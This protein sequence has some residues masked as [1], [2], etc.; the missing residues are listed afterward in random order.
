MKLG[1]LSGYSTDTS[2]IVCFSGNSIW[3]FYCRCTTDSYLNENLYFIVCETQSK[4][5][6][7]DIEYGVSVPF[8]TVDGPPGCFTEL[9]TLKSS[10]SR[11]LLLVVP[12]GYNRNAAKSALFICKF[13]RRALQYYLTFRRELSLTLKS[14][15]SSCTAMDEYKWK[16]VS[17]Q[18]F[19]SI[20]TKDRYCYCYY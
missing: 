14:L 17:P 5:F 13:L 9:M 4:G 18:I 2:W 10:V 20:N 15:N 12:T 3:L 19:L 6:Q 1:S 7:C 16:S 11:S 8:Y